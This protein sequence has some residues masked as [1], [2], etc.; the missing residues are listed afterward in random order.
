MYLFD[1]KRV[2]VQPPAAAISAQEQDT[3]AGDEKLV[4]RAPAFVP[5]AAI[6]SSGMR[7]VGL[8][9]TQAAKIFFCRLSR[10][11]QK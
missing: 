2:F 1:A 7:Q 6:R 9:C 11:F 4:S 8:A 3:H 5:Q 10:A